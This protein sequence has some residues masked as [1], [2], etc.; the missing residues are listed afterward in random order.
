MINT[1]ST[2]HVAG[3]I[4]YDIFISFRCGCNN[5]LLWFNTNFDIRQTDLGEVLRGVP[6][7]YFLIGIVIGLAVHNSVL[8]N[9]PIPSS[10]YKGSLSQF[11]FHLADP[12][13]VLFLFFRSNGT[14]KTYI[15]R[16]VVSR[17]KPCKRFAKCPGF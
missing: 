10:V 1:P 12:Y 5:S 11:Y 13:C 7:I 8:L 17:R 15:I 4:C 2:E 9:F 14:D 3:M 6:S 16:F